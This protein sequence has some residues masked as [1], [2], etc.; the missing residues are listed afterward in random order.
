MAFD[1]NEI[2]YCKLI[3]HGVKRR[4]QIHPNPLYTHVLKPSIS[5]KY[6]TLIYLLSQQMKEY[7]MNIQIDLDREMPLFKAYYFVKYWLL[8]CFAMTALLTLQ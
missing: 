3:I 1:A 4:S 2:P 5:G 7:S 6:L 8:L